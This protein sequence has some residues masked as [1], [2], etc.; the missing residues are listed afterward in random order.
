VTV[1]KVPLGAA[2][3]LPLLATEAGRAGLMD[4]RFYGHFF[5]QVR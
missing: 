2:S 5:G 4:W 1:A 3:H